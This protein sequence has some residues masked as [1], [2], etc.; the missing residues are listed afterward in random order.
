M[1]ATPYKHKTA[2]P[3]PFKSIAIGQGFRQCG[4]GDEQTAYSDSLFRRIA[5]PEDAG[6][7]PGCSDC[8]LPYNQVYNAENITGR[9]AWK[10]HFC[11]NRNVLAILE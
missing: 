7:E 1:K 6:I 3:V 5:T 10:V 8:K 11:P 4:L 2:V 9:Q